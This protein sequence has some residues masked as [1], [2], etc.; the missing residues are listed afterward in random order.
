MKKEI[1]WGILLNYILIIC[2]NISSILVVP[3][4]IE[5]MGM[6]IYGVYLLVFSTIA[7]FAVSDFGIG[8]SVIS[9]IAKFKAAK[10][11][12][13]LENYIFWMFW[14]YLALALV[15][16]MLCS[17]IYICSPVF[18]KASLVWNEILMFRKMFFIMSINCLLLFI[19]N[20][21]FSIITGL[22]KLAFTRI[23]NIIKIIIRTA[24]FLNATAFKDISYFV[25]VDLLL[26]I[27]ITIAF[28][29][30]ALKLGTKMKC[31]FFDKPLLKQNISSIMSLYLMPISENFYWSVCNIIIAMHIGA[32]S[33]GQ[34]AIAVTFC[35]IYI[36][37]SATLAHF[38]ISRVSEIW[39]LQKE[40]FK[41]YIFYTSRKQIVLLGA[42]LI[43]FILL[44][45]LFL[46]IW[47]GE[48]FGISYYI[49]VI[50][51]AALFFPSS[52]SMLEVWLY[53]RNKYFVRALILAC[54][55]VANTILIW[56][57]APKFGLIGIAGC[58]VVTTIVFKFIAMNIYYHRLNMYVKDFNLG[59][60]AKSLP[61][62]AIAITVGLIIFKFVS[63]SIV[64]ML[65]NGIFA[66]LIYVTILLFTY[67]KSTEKQRLRDMF[68]MF[69][70]F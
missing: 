30:Y 5:S 48:D 44:G 13:S 40:N 2:S 34:F 10:D 29:I 66:L 38:R 68:D 70:P 15:V 67:V 59:I 32:S 65:L 33:I 17:V 41:E 50:I 69:I 35:Q 14:V 4:L 49:A 23:C 9:H 20:F 6:E 56:F 36:Q 46:R 22:G 47:V 61:A 62:L 57:Y 42:I 63:G 55:A 60:I 26:T 45:Q 1:R 16:L 39:T 25:F 12:V 7:F 24:L 8:T 54:S 27:L 28:L 18:F 64:L 37:L 21:L 58:I 43:E 19:Q 11:D 51:I 3:S 31:H 53:V 52:Q